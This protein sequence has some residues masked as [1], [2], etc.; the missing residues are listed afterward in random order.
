LPSADQADITAAIPATLVL[1]RGDG[2][3]VTCSFKI[4]LND[5]DKL[6]QQFRGF[7]S[8]LSDQTA[9]TVDVNGI[10]RWP[11]CKGLCDKL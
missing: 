11:S 10:G 8:D 2:K 1:E 5:L 3:S 9:L 6:R 7:L 4:L